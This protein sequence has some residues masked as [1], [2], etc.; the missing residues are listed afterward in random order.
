[1]GQDKGGLV[2]AQLFL[3]RVL[4]KDVHCTRRPK[5]GSGNILAG[6]ANAQNDQLFSGVGQSTPLWLD[7]RHLT[8]KCPYVQMVL[9][10][11]HRLS[12]QRLHAS[13]FLVAV[14][15]VGRRVGVE[16]LLGEFWIHTR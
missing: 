1:M 12:F 8:Q 16:L 2:R 10:F 7:D 11:G 6:I 14:V 13:F 5:P 4:N 9:L 15:D 3:L